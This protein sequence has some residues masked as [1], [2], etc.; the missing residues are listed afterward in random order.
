MKKRINIWM[1]ILWTLY[2]ISGCI[3]IINHFFDVKYIK[4]MAFVSVPYFIVFSFVYAFF[5]RK[6]KRAEAK[7][8]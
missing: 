6:K 2:V 1:T 7:E 4:E 8:K 5:S 3:N